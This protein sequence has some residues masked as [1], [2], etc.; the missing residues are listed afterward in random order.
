MQ[1]GDLVMAIYLKKTPRGKWYDGV[2]LY[3]VDLIQNYMKDNNL[4]DKDDVGE[5]T[6]KTLLNGSLDWHQFST[7]GGGLQFPRKICARLLSPSAQMKTNY[8]EW[9]PSKDEDWNELEARALYQAWL[10]IKDVLADTE[11]G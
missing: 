8:G 3:A 11:A 4:D 2:S 10:L 6:E 1:Y 7:T 5:I 9:K